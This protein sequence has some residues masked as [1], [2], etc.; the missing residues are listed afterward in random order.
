M[1]LTLFIQSPSVLCFPPPSALVFLW[2][3][4][5]HICVYT[6]KSESFTVAKFYILTQSLQHLY[7]N[8]L[9]SSL[10]RLFILVLSIAVQITSKAQLL[11]TKNLYYLGVYVSRSQV[12]FNWVP[13]AQV[14]S[15]GCSQGG[16]TDLQ[17]FQDNTWKRISFQAYFWDVSPQR[18][19]P[20]LGLS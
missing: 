15:Q 16:P 8:C 18:S 9:S 5:Q 12:P 11:K 7:Y 2:V 1:L 4:R 3:V 6:R 10:V 20:G 13:L 14:L 19:L 17:L